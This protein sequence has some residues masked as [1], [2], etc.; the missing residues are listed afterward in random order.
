MWLHHLL[1]LLASAGTIFFTGIGNTIAGWLI[2]A[3][4]AVSFAV[5]ALHKKKQ[6]NGWLSM[7]AHWREEYRPAAKFALW[8]C[9]VFYG[10]VVIWSVV[11]AVYE[12]HQYFVNYVWKHKAAD[13]QSA[14]AAAIT[15]DGLNGQISDLK[16]KCAG[17]EGANGVMLD[18]NRDQQNT[19]NKCQE[20]AINRMAPEPERHSIEEIAVGKS[21]LGHPTKV[22]VYTTNKTITPVVVV[23]SCDSPI[24]ELQGAIAGTTAMLGT[25]AAP[26][27]PQLPNTWS[28]SIASPAWTP[29]TPIT[30]QFSYAE[31]EAPKCLFARR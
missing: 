24:D 13:K 27:G 5:A 23:V 22:F 8:C 16:A 3:G 19:I 18:Q 15:Q 30:I 10:P 21:L 26:M 2:D 29:D 25:L 9:L 6:E 1:N 14:A 31:K 17:L 11:K 12:D 4:F 20:D 28:F 7:L